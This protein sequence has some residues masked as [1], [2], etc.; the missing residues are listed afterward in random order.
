MDFSKDLICENVTA[1]A[2]VRLHFAG[3]DTTALAAIHIHIPYL[4][5]YIR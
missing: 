2:D 3:Q 4:Q 5:K 1:T